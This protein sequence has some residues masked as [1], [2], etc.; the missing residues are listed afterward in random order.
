MYRANL[1]NNFTPHNE[2]SIFIVYGTDGTVQYQ[3]FQRLFRFQQHALSRGA[4]E[5]HAPPAINAPPEPQKIRSRTTNKKK[6]PCLADP[7]QKDQ[8]PPPN[9][10]EQKPHGECFTKFLSAALIGCS[11]TNV[12]YS[13]RKS[14]RDCSNLPATLPISR[15]VNAPTAYLETSTPPLQ[16]NN[17]MNKGN[18]YGMGSQQPVH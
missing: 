2:N 14:R 10:R 15:P 11:R 7:I 12:R 9:L 4:P 8:I 5:P 17:G 18:S 1:L 3:N 13:D 6:T 16:A